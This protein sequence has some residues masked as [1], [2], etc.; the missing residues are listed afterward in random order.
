MKHLN[1]EKASA[2]LLPLP[3]RDMNKE[4]ARPVAG[5]TVTNTE[6]VAAV[7]VTLHRAQ[8]AA[9]LREEPRYV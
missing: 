6:N 5:V 2:I 3:T 4:E 8:H 9:P 7:F 1:E